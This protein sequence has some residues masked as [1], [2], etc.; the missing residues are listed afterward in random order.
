MAAI[1]L[2]VGPPLF[3]SID[4]ERP[5]GAVWEA[6]STAGYLKRC[7]PFCDSTEV[8]SWPGPGSKDSITYFSGIRYQRHFV[9]WEE[10][11]GYDIELGLRPNLTARVLWRVESLPDRNTRFSI[12]VFPLIRGDMETGKKQRYQERLF[13]PVLAHYLDC[14]MQGVKHF[15]IT[16]IPVTANQFGPNPLYSAAEAG[17]D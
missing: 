14:V 11:I 17:A 12:E 1:G 5:A 4:I 8:E 9:A 15:V 2:E 3:A 10:G 16:G 7:H 6:I 13:G